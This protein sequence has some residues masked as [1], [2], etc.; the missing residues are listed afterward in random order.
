MMIAIGVWPGGVAASG[1]TPNIPATGDFTT[2][3]PPAPQVKWQRLD[4]VNFALLFPEEE[5]A[6]VVIFGERAEK[7]RQHVVKEIGQDFKIKIKV[8]LA[9]DRESYRALLGGSRR[10]EWSIGSALAGKDTIVMFSP[11]GSYREKVQADA[12]QVFAHELAHI[13]LFNVLRR[14]DVPRWL[15]EGVAQMVAREWNKSDSV[16]LTIAVLSD[17]LIPLADLADHWPSD[18]TQAKL[19]YA[20][21]LSLVLFLRDNLYLTPL[22][23]AMRDGTDWLT[24][25]RKVTEMDFDTFLGQWHDYLKRKHTWILLFDEGCLWVFMALLLVAGYFVVKLQRRRQYARLDDQERGR[26]KGRHYDDIDDLIDDSKWGDGW[27]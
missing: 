22:L 2:H 15:T 20:E 26:R 12:A 13:A 21:S 16:R 11:R 8:Y 24:A 25:L 23:V 14:K 10:S 1:P 18:K 27:Y 17:N 19:A 4:T 7:I 3:R 6:G 5:A 9:P